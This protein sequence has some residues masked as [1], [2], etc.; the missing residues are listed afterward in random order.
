MA[1][2]SVN[3]CIAR[4]LRP[5]ATGLNKLLHYSW[6]DDAT[7]AAARALLTVCCERQMLLLMQVVKCAICPGPRM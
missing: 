4:A 1:F 6:M 5:A 3:I 7:V 2:T